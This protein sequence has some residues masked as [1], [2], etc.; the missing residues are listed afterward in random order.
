MNAKNKSILF[1]GISLIALFFCIY[2]S[3]NNIKKT[4][5]EGA[6]T[7]LQKKFTKTENLLQQ[8]VDSISDLKIDNINDL[9]NFCERNKINGNE[10]IFYIYQDSLLKAWSSSEISLPSV[11]KQNT[12]ATVCFLLKEIMFTILTTEILLLMYW[13]FI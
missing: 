13:D 2:I 5:P 4:T 8:Y 3:Q 12:K 7:Y 6:K 10:F 11:L 1:F 9:L